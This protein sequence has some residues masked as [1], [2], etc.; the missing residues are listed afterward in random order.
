MDPQSAFSRLAPPEAQLPVGVRALIDIELHMCSTSC[1]YTIPIYAPVRARRALEEFAHRQVGSPPAPE[2]EGV[3]HNGL[4][5][6]WIKNNTLSVDGLPGLASFQI[7]ASESEQVRLLERRQLWDRK[8]PPAIEP[9]AVS[10]PPWPAAK[11]P[12]PA[13]A[14]QRRPSLLS[15]C[16]LALVIGLASDLPSEATFLVRSCIRA[17]VALAVM[18]LMSRA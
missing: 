17:A 3:V 7:H 14:S 9:G 15:A 13:V 11:A 10:D 2:H 18:Q 12:P 1:G 16:L 4:G 5:S 8:A 6:Y